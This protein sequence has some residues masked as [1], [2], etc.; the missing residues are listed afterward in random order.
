MAHEFGSD[1]F[2]A[3]DGFSAVV[4]VSSVCR[5]LSGRLQG[6]EFLLLGSVSLSGLRATHRA[7]KFAGHRSLPTLATAEAVSH[8]FSR[9]HLAQHAGARQRNARLAHLCRFRPGAHHNGS[10][11]LSPRTVR[12]GVGRDSLCTGLHDHRSLF[13]DVSLGAVP[14]P[15]KRRQGT[16]PARSAGQHSDQ[17]LCDQRPAERC[18]TSI[19]STNCCPKREL[20][21]CSTAV[22]WTSGVSTCS[23]KAAPSS[24]PVP[25]RTRSSGDA[26]GGPS[27][28]PPDCGRIK[29]FSS[30]ARKLLAC[31]P[32]PCAAF[33]TSTPKKNYGWFSSPTI[34]C[35]RPSR[36]PN[37][38]ELA[39][40]WN[41]S[42]GGSS[43]ICTSRAS[44]ALPRTL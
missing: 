11:A 17:C 34:S 38:T 9:P 35:F 12:C 4:G 30:P 39:G 36:L 22:T 6:P 44:W 40:K 27:A 24:S 23:R 13:V 26:S 14:S 2:C 37:C 25:N 18:T 41:C 31:I 43:N 32:T 16:R 33:I 8:G 28:V 1:D 20:F 10:R 42:S 15:Q 21:I 7:R 19:F 29:P 3:S 5:A